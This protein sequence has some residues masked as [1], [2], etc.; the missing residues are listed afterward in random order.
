MQSIWK[1]PL[2][3]LEAQEIQI[4]SHSQ[5]LCVQAQ[6]GHPMLWA[7]VFDTSENAPTTLRTFHTYGTG[8]RHESIQ[9]KYVGTY[10]IND[11]ALVFHVFEEM[12]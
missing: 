11:G 9:G 4:P 3:I 5:V 10:Q 8:H 2:E 6:N 1:F 12:T 7:L